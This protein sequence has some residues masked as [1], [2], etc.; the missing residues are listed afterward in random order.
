M[1]RLYIVFIAL[2]T[3]AMLMSC[4]AQ[5]VVSIADNEYVVTETANGDTINDAE[6]ILAGLY[7]LAID[8]CGSA[9][10]RE[11]VITLKE[12]VEYSGITGNV[13]A[14]LRFG[15]KHRY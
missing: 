2:V 12:E 10:G 6:L 11:N 13:K 4:T 8:F 9:G 5:G 3:S 14:S 15:C 1:T 7:V